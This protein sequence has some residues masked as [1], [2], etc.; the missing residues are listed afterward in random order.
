MRYLRHWVENQDHWHQYVRAP[1]DVPIDTIWG[2]LGDQGPHLLRSITIPAKCYGQQL[3]LLRLRPE[4]H[5]PPSIWSAW[6]LMELQPLR[7][8]KPMR[9]TQFRT[10]M[11]F[12]REWIEETQRVTRPDRAIG[13]QVEQ[14]LEDLGTNER[15]FDPAPTQILRSMEDR[16]PDL[17]LSTRHPPDQL[18]VIPNR[19]TETVTSDVLTESASEEEEGKCCTF[20]CQPP[21]MPEPGLIRA[22]DFQKWMSFLRPWVDLREARFHGPWENLHSP[23]SAETDE[24]NHWDEH[25]YED[26]DPGWTNTLVYEPLTRTFVQG[27]RTRVIYRMFG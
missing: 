14:Y 15:H 16:W 20:D 5:P 8:A 24:E 13:D 12:L 27:E 2:T 23:G 22:T 18:T 19:P 1:F 17:V 3:F 6:R 10:W 26:T 11:R 25:S 4:N 21:A 7:F 9:A